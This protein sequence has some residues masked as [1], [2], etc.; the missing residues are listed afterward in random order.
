MIR[1]DIRM[2]FIIQEHKPSPDYRIKEKEKV[3]TL[4]SRPKVDSRIDK[5]VS[6]ISSLS[7][8][9]TAII[10]CMDDRTLSGWSSLSMKQNVQASL[11]N[12]KRIFIKEKA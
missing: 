10:F 9:R 2:R 1:D 3:L 8:K 11:I 4:F 7:S 12:T 5:R 6:W